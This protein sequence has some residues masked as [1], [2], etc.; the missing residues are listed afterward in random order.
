MTCLVAVAV[1]VAVAAVVAAYPPFRIA[2]GLLAG[3][4]AGPLAEPLWQATLAVV[5][6]AGLLRAGRP[7]WSCLTLCGSWRRLRR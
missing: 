1:V 4:L 7:G 5:A 6:A 2:A 3:F